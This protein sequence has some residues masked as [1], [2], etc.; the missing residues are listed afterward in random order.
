MTTGDQAFVIVT[1]HGSNVAGQLVVTNYGTGALVEMYTNA[2]NFRDG[3]F[4][5]S[6]ADPAQNNLVLSDFVF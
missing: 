5:V 4:F 1:A 2:D 6:Y 3:W